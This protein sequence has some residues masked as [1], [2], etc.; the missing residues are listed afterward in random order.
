MYRKS[1]NVSDEQKDELL[2]GA[3]TVDDPKVLKTVEQGLEDGK[4]NA[5][6]F[7]TTLKWIEHSK[8]QEVT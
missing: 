3:S 4:I 2:S 1:Y 5:T 8:A 6:N 7:R